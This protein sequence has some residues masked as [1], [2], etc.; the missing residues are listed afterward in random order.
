MSHPVVQRYRQRMMGATSEGEW[1]TDGWLRDRH[2]QHAVGLGAGHGLFELGLLEAT[3]IESY[4]LYDLSEVSL[5]QARTAAQQRGL[6]ERLATHSTDVNAVDLGQALYDLVTFSSSLHHV[7]ELENVV[8]KVA[9]S[10]GDN[11]LLFASEYI[12]PDRFQWGE[13]EKAIVGK[14]YTSLDQRLRF[15][16]PPRPAPL[17]LRLRRTPPLPPISPIPWPNARQIAQDDP[18][19]AVHSADIV[20]T[21]NRHFQK[22]EVTPMGG[23]LALPLW[24]ALNHNYLFED[25]NGVRFVEVLVELD[26]A[27]TD[28]GMLPSYFALIVASEPRASGSLSDSSPIADG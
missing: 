17:R 12:G 2:I 21:L 3:A 18:T 16:W 1:L 11:G 28:S 6:S 27:L 13:I 9:R 20:A 25:K 8:G 7:T 24:G 4:D 22:V 19:E 5:A 15:N 10:L 23:A 14:L 26:R